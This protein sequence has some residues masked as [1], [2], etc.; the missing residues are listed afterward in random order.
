MQVPRRALVGTGLAAVA[1]G[2]VAVSPGA[3]LGR[4]EALSADPLLF[5][6]AVLALYA[7][8]PLLVLP[9][10]LCAAA[11]GYGYG[12]YG[13]P[14]ALAGAGLTAVPPYYAARWTLSGETTTDRS[15]PV[16][17]LA[18]SAGRAR[19]AGRTYF[20]T[21]GGV[22]G[23]AAARLVPIPADVVTCAAGASGVSLP[24]LV[25][26]TVLGEVPW[27]VGAV[28]VGASAG[29]L[30]DAGDLTAIGA[31]VVVAAGAGAA[32]LLFGPL[33]RYLGDDPAA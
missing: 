12:A 16:G 25:A 9:T 33:Y 24:A 15:G 2:A 23:V 3:V 19:E 31:P 28:L 18:G 1:L 22:R 30:A 4:L 21:T 17:W 8:R 29:R 14:V 26:G 7:V 5:G 11:V 6:V 13:I 32:L 20:S 27:T 10:T